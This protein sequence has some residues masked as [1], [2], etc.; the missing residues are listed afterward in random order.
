M[1]GLI[2]CDRR[3]FKDLKYTRPSTQVTDC[4]QTVWP[5]ARTKIFGSFAT[6]LSLPSSDVDLLVC[7]PIVR[8][9]LPIEEAGILE[10]HKAIEESSLREAARRIGV[11]TQPNVYLRSAELVSPQCREFVFKQ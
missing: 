8:N 11:S 10:G 7:L 6:G 2:S 3:L 9:L 1:C 4:L 5:R